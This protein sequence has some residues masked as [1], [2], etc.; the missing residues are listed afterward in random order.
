M[1]KFE[2]NRARWIRGI[3]KFKNYSNSSGIF[4]GKGSK[5]ATDTFI[6]N[7]SRFNGKVVIKGNGGCRI[8]NYVAFGDQIILITSNHNTESVNLQYALA[9][10]IGN[11]ARKSEKSGIT[12]GHN[13]WVGD[14]AIIVAGVS[15]GN[16]AVI[17]AGSVV[18]KDV[19][20]YAIV[21]GVPA[22]FIRY[23]M[24]EEQIKN[25]ESMKWWDWPIEK[26]KSNRN[27]LN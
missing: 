5:I 21:G 1:L 26:M 9:K 3:L 11:K 15:V 12:I 7:G 16:G 14:R 27:L 22:K 13:V 8:G 6:G 10:K 20:P 25:V 18:T 23:R 4:I 24:S 2:G 17:G 19:P